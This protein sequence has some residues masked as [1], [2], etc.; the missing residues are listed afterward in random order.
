MSVSADRVRIGFVLHVMQV[1]GAEVLVAETI[2]RLGTRLDPVIFCLDDIG[3]LGEQLQRDGVP[4]IAFG[5]RPGLDLRVA[6]RLA[7]E[8]RQRHVEVLH[9]HQYT[10]FFYTALSRLLTPGRVHVMFTEH[11]RHYPD[12]VSSKRRLANRLVFGRLADEIHGVCRF[13]ADSLARVDG[14]RQPIDVIANGIDLSRYSTISREQARQQ[15]DLPQD[16]S[17]VACVARFHPVKDHAMLLRAFARVASAVPTADLLLAGDGPLRGALTA[18]AADLGI[19]DR[20][21]F[22]GIRHDVPQLL[23]AANVFALTSISEAA[24]LTLLEAMACRLPVVVTAV[25]G[26]PEIVQHDRQGYLVPRGDDAAAA[27]AIV[28]LLGDPN[29]AAAMGDAGYNTVAAHYRLEDTI[30]A[31]YARYA[32]AAA[33][34]RTH[35]ATTESPARVA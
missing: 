13:S 3:T 29:R 5:R 15:L 11:G 8:I 24:S 27:D 31:Y 1:A 14:F 19:A 12:I 26:N 4:V 23:R 6:K 9:A 35:T 33:R 10:P 17:F 30:D 34:L 22:L 18:Q 2:R 25:G 16:R 20:V 32:A 21:R 28:R 7:R